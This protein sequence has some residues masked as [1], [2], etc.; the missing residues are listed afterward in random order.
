M[1]LGPASGGII[2]AT[3]GAGW[4]LAVDAASFVVAAALYA[5]LRLPD[6][7]RVQQSST[8]SELRDGWGEFASRTWLWVVVLAFSMMNALY[9]GSWTTLGPVVA[10]GSFG[11][12]G[13]GFALAAMA[14]GMLVGTLLLLRFSWTHPIRI[15][16]VGA[17]LIAVPIAA[18]GLSTPLAILLVAAVVGGIGFDIFGINWETTMQQQIPEQ[19]LSRVSSYDMLGSIVAIPAGQV[20]AG[21]AAEVIGARSVILGAAVLYVVVG[22]VTLFT[23]AVWRL[24]APEPS[25]ERSSATS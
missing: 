22:A 16:M 24:Q 11:A 13:W 10:E 2:V 1:M 7:A 18:L 19:L 9:S 17:L 6:A 5:R 23:P 21:F 14:F 4:G 20:L 12:S 8:F 15:G 25:T 3:A